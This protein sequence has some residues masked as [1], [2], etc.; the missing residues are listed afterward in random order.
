MADIVEAHRQ[1]EVRPTLRLRNT[2]D[3]AIL[4]AMQASLRQHPGISEAYVG[5][6][7]SEYSEGVTAT[8]VL[9]QPSTP[10]AAVD[11]ATRLLADACAAAGLTVDVIKEVVVEMAGV[12]PRSL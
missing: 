8:I 7:R 4:D 12:D 2:A 9:T 5:L 1:W 10:G 11:E 3:R 6:E